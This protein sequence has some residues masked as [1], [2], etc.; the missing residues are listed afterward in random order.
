MRLKRL[1]FSMCF[2]NLTENVDG[3]EA[4]ANEE[5]LERVTA[6]SRREKPERLTGEYKCER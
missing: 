1:D 2:R 6:C 3:Q 5:V 4:E